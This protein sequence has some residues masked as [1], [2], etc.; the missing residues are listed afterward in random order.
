MT[1]FAQSVQEAEPDLEFV[2]LTSIIHRARGFAFEFYVCRILS[3]GQFRVYV[4]K[5][6]E[7]C[8]YIFDPTHDT[9]IEG[10]CATEAAVIADLLEAARNDVEENFQDVY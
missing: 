4:A 2:P 7:G 9:R 1:P 3:S 10:G 8:G 6:G 5:D